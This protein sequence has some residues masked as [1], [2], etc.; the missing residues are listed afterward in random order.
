[1]PLDSFLGTTVSVSCFSLVSIEPGAVS[2]PAP[3]CWW[4]Y[5]YVMLEGDFKAVRMS[6]QRIGDNLLFMRQAHH[7]GKSVQSSHRPT[8]RFVLEWCSSCASSRLV[9]SIAL[10]LRL[11][12][13][14]KD[15]CRRAGMIAR[16]VIAL[17]DSSS[18]LRPVL[19][20]RAVWTSRWQQMYWGRWELYVRITLN[21]QNSTDRFKICWSIQV[22]AF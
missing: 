17:H 2:S 5:R 8:S 12:R 7:A 1:M 10:G 9:G 16:R 14:L 21:I 18:L 22:T 19:P 20:R 6:V 4:L 11:A 15:I 13:G 3:F